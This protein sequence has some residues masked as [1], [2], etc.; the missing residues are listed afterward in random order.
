MLNGN[1]L[2]NEDRLVDPIVFNEAAS[3]SIGFPTTDNRYYLSDDGTGFYGIPGD[4]ENDTLTWSFETNPTHDNNTTSGSNQTRDLYRAV[5]F[6]PMVNIYIDWPNDTTTI[7]Y[8]RRDDAWRMSSR[9]EA[10][11]TRIAIDL[12]QENDYVYIA[13]HPYFFYE[14]GTGWH[15][16]LRE[17]TWHYSFS[18]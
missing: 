15:E 13:Q 7:F 12:I 5:N 6:F 17:F 11:I 8:K 9:S 2:R 10:N 18:D 1:R 4:P 16:T 3:F 14:D